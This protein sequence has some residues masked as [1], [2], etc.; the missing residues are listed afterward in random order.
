MTNSNCLEGI[1][2]PAC[3]NE[4]R[5]RIACTTVFTVTDEGTEDHGDIEWDDDSYAECPECGRRGTLKVFK[6]KTSPLPPDPDGMNFDRSSWADRAI[7]AF[8]DASGTDMEDALSDLLADLMHWADRTNYDFE[9]AL[10]RA[11]G[12]YGAETAGD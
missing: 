5:F 4:D 10:D 9:A 7:S 8:R 3:G 11:R 6:P 1:K 12:H 2:C